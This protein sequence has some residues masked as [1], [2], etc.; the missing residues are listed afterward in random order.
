[1]NKS[2]SFALSKFIQLFW[3]GLCLDNAREFFKSSQIYLSKGRGWG[4]CVC[5]CLSLS[6]MATKKIKLALSCNMPRI[7]INYDVHFSTRSIKEV[8][9]KPRLFLKK[10]RVRPQGESGLRS[11]GGGYDRPRG[12]AFLKLN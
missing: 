4:V 12:E 3:I 9:T 7:S 1:V 2:V 6:H 8:S 11:L 5:V 10:C